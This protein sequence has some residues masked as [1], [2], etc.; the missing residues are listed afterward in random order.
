MSLIASVD[1]LEKGV[2]I[3]APLEGV[4]FD[5]HDVLMYA[6]Y[7]RYRLG[8]VGLRMFNVQT[9]EDQRSETG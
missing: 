2:M 6:P 4:N 9:S 3:F 1:Q 8:A 7:E 5:C